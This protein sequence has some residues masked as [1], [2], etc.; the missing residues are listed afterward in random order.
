MTRAASDPARLLAD[1]NP[2]VRRRAAQALAEHDA[3]GVGELVLRALSDE[4]WRVRK[5]AVGVAPLVPRRDE[6]L[7]ALAGGLADRDDVGLRNAAVE[8]LIAI[9]PDAIPI[10]IDALAKLDADGRKLAVEALGGIPDDRTAEALVGGLGDQD[11]N[12]RYAIVEALGAVA[13][14]SDAV[15]QRA[16]NALAELL[17]DDDTQMRIAALEALLRLEAPLGFRTLEPLLGDPILRRLAMKALGHSPEE[18]AALTLAHTLLDPDPVVAAFALTALATWIRLASRRPLEFLR[19]RLVKDG[20]S[21]RALPK[22]DKPELRADVLLV[23]AVVA[24]PDEVGAVLAA[25]EDPDLAPQLEDATTILARDATGEL[26]AQLGSITS[27]RRAE[28]LWLVAG[29]GAVLLP[30]AL[31]IVRAQLHAESADVRSAALHILSMRGD[32]RDLPRALT[33]LDDA[34]VRAAGAASS[35]VLAMTVRFPSVARGELERLTGGGQPSLA[36]SVLLLGLVR[37][38]AQREGDVELL[39][40]AL[41]AGATKTRRAAVEALAELGGEN[42]K[43]LAVSALADEEREVR[44]AAVRTLGVLAH[45]S[46]LEELIDQVKDLE[47]IAAACRALGTAN[48]DRCLAVAQRL[49]RSSDAAIACAAVEAA[50]PLHGA[51]REDVLLAAMEHRDAE[52]VKL[53]LSEV[54]RSQSARSLARLGL[55]LDHESWEVRRLAAELL[56]EQRDA[57]AQALLRGRLER[58]TDPGVRESIVSA[59]GRTGHEGEGI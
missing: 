46:A 16:W 35:A 41:N 57:P 4:D 40:R 36:V 19:E 53:A 21:A 47:T 24:G 26:L 5:E 30:D 32:A 22:L 31:E 15:R 8:A 54:H 42:A 11:P 3:P 9:G 34:D 10:A 14:T 43:A 44:L 25:L 1:A 28:L 39:R 17:D 52:V 49:V 51:R 55:C 27:S 23:S 37:A 18:E 6:V 29:S 33:A 58:E 48:P 50:G 59:L 13:V 2:E 7:R 45:E 56:G 38:G 20:T 12:V